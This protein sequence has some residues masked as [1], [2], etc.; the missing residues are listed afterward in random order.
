MS[1]NTLKRLFKKT[2]SILLG[3]LFAFSLICN[4]ACT[5]KTVSAEEYPVIVSDESADEKTTS[6][7]SDDEEEGL[8]DGNIYSEPDYLRERGEYKFNPTALHPGYVKQVIKNPKILD[9]AKRV[10]QTVYDLE[11]KVD[12]TGLE[13]TKDEFRLAC[14]LADCSTPLMVNVD[15]NYDD[16]ENITVSYRTNPIVTD[17]NKATYEVLDKEEGRAQIDAF[18]DYV[19]E[20]INNNLTSESTDADRARIIY[21]EIIKEKK[22]KFLPDENDPVLE[23]DTDEDIRYSVAFRDIDEET[24]GYDILYLYQFFMTQLNIS[25]RLVCAPGKFVL[26]CEGDEMLEAVTELMKDFWIWNVVEIEGNA[27]NCD[28][29]LDKISFDSKNAKYGTDVPEMKFF[30]MSDETREKSYKK[31]Y[32]LDL[33]TMDPTKSTDIPACEEDLQ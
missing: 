15:I 30:G 12:M 17:G 32:E 25:C 18:V 6:K 16:M 11:D 8:T 10:M 7:G 3:F 24:S 21:E 13:C 33:Y 26:D 20:T 2:I 9:A 31:Y 27:Y 29:I 5:Q 28:L 19:T 14:E 4:T 22:A 23:S 1:V